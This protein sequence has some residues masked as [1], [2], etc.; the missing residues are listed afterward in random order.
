MSPRT[1]P[2]LGDPG[3]Q[4]LY[5]AG[6]SGGTEIDFKTYV[7]HGRGSRRVTFTLSAA[8]V[9]GIADSYASMP[10]GEG[11]E[12]HTLTTRIVHGRSSR[13][14]QFGVP[15]ADLLLLAKFLRAAV[16]T[17]YS[18]AV[19]HFNHPDDAWPCGS[20]E[21]RPPG[22]DGRLTPGELAAND[23]YGNWL[24]RMLAGHS[25]TVK[26][27]P[28]PGCGC[29]LKE[30]E[31]ACIKCGPAVLDE[32][33]AVA[34][35]ADAVDEVNREYPLP[36]CK[37]GRALLDHADERLALPCG[38]RML[39]EYRRI[40]RAFRKLYEAVD[41][42]SDEIRL[43]GPVVVALLEAREAARAEIER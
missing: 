33:R 40:H 11:P 32:R 38:C 4:P 5:V 18:H 20:C 25:P 15:V 21:Q 26:P 6:R 16:P 42:W 31:A 3:H 19:W 29:D 43:T 24:P 2:H 1:R 22:A 12:T 36:R 17:D 35:L 13:A 14:I 30:W 9:I 28:C 41:A 23:D 37:H 39:D 8:D 10:T 27:R 34:N 7:R